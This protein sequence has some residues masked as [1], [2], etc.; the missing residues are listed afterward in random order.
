MYELPLKDAKLLTANGHRYY[1]WDPPQT[2]ENYSNRPS[3]Y[4]KT[5]LEV[6][7]AAGANPKFPSQ[8]LASV[9]TDVNA[10]MTAILEY[11]KKI[12]DWSM[13]SVY[14]QNGWRPDDESQGIA[15]VKNIKAVIDGDAR[16][17]KLGFPPD[18]EDEAK[19]VL[20]RRGDPRREAFRKKWANAP[21]WSQDSMEALFHLVDRVYAPRGFNPHATGLVFDLDFMIGYEAGPS[22][23]HETLVETKPNRNGAA[24]QSA[25]GMWLNL[26][27]MKFHFDSYDTSA[28][29]WHMEYR[30]S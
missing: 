20:G 2:H 21:G 9:F 12:D 10:L 18:L 19:G 17:K 16:F 14:V 5:G 11:G 24:L 30:K 15:Y 27:S 6:Y 23:A 3:V 26:Y 13:Q 8:L 1:L 29:I 4:P 25:L 28:E 22:V 7:K